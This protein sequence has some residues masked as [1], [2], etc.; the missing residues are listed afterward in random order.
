MLRGLLDEALDVPAG[1]RWQYHVRLALV[2]A[3][4]VDGDNM[5]VVTGASHRLY[6]AGDAGP[7]GVAQPFRFD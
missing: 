3:E 1:Q 2:I 6:L 7:D 5:R 4:I